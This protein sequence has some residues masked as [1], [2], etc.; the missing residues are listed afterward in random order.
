MK[1]NKIAI[2]EGIVGGFL[3][4]CIAVPIIWLFWGA[5][6]QTKFYTII[7]TSEARRAANEYIEGK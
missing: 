4:L 6:I 5:E 1:K 7:N 2:A 3:F